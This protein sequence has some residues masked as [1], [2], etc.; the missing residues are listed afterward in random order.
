[1]DHISAIV[2]IILIVVAMVFAVRSGVAPAMVAGWRI[3]A[4]TLEAIVHV[5]LGILL[6]VVGVA[7]ALTLRDFLG[8]AIG[9]ACLY[10]GG[11]LLFG[12]IGGFVKSSKPDR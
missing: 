3:I 11:N 7:I 4:L 2:V 1:M 8:F 5:P 6:I 10:S 12:A 9:G